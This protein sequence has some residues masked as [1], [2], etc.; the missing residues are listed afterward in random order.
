M[1]TKDVPYTTEDR[2]WDI[3]LNVQTD[4]YLQTLVT[5][6]MLEDRERNKFKYILVGGLEIG[7]RPNHTDYQVRHLHIAVIFHNRA[8]KSSIIN[9]WGIKE[10]N[11]YYMVPRNREQPYSGW[12]AHHIKEFSKVS[13][14][15]P[16]SFIIYENGELPQDHGKRKAVVLRSEVEKKMKTDEIIVDMRK[17]MRRGKQMYY[18]A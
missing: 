6:I 10:G 16:D 9:N 17:L 3:R 11:G 4:D 1:A 5:N 13:T 2:Q 7:T 8:S 15:A 12:R 14:H 18:R